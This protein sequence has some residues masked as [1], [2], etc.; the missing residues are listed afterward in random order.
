MKI[1]FE[2][3]MSYFKSWK[4]TLSNGEDGRSF[5]IPFLANSEPVNK[6]IETGSPDEIKELISALSITDINT[7]ISVASEYGAQKVITAADIP[8][9]SLFANG[10]Y[11]LPELLEFAPDGL[12]LYEIGYK[13]K[14]SK[15]LNGQIKYGENHAM[16]AALAG[17]VTITKSKPYIVKSTALAK[18]LI[19]VNQPLK[20][21]VLRI[22]FLQSP[23]VRHFLSALMADS[24][25]YRNITSCLK[26][27]TSYR[28][29]TS[30]KDVMSFVLKDSYLENAL[31][32][33]D[34]KV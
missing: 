9:F 6:T 4:E 20:D 11:R 24:A 18:T 32:N 16:L 5:F 2:V 21:K 27:S 12:M 3:N 34:W 8:C 15:N 13:L 26:D 28:R 17:L 14:H 22:M 25:S 23:F 31:A 33:M 7:I 29:R 19:L 30:V 1:T 10:V